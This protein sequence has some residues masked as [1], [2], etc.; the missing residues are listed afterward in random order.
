MVF[1]HVMDDFAAAGWQI[2][3]R[4]D[5]HLDVLLAHPRQVDPEA[6]AERL[7][8]ALTARGV[9]APIDRSSTRGSERRS[10]R[11]GICAF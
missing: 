2:A 6:L 10:R 7:R 8:S 5:G 11:Y 1:H 9:V 3:Q 4:D